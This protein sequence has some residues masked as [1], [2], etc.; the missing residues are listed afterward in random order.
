MMLSVV[1]HLIYILVILVLGFVL[2]FVSGR[3]S[4][5]RQMEERRAMAKRRKER[6]AAV[7]ADEEA[8]QNSVEAPPESE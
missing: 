4:L 5:I 8:K 3:K 7:K 6:L 2:G 1:D